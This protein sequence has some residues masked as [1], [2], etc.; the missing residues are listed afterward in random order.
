MVVTLLTG[1]VT[2]C[3]GNV[4]LLMLGKWL[5]VNI[6]TP[7]TAVHPQKYKYRVKAQAPRLR[8]PGGLDLPLRAGGLALKRRETPRSVK[9]DPG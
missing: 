3:Y 2:A 1:F 5:V 4:A 8:E 9:A 6:V 7:V